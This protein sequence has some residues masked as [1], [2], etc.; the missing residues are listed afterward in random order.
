MSPNRISATLAPTD[1][2]AIVQ[3]IESLHKKSRAHCLD[4]VV[5]KQKEYIAKAEAYIEQFGGLCLTS[6]EIAYAIDIHPSDF[7]R[8]FRKAKG[9][10]PKKYLDE[11]LK[12]RVVQR[13]A[14]ENVLGYTISYELGFSSEQA[15]YRWVKRVFGVSFKELSAQHRNCMSD[16]TLTNV[17]NHLSRRDGRKVHPQSL[18]TRNM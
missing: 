9:L 3:A 15:F 5:N 10:T 16:F 17:P 2:I 8:T 1:R 13:L 12:E 6:K 7:V 18:R 4:N 11:K 14:S